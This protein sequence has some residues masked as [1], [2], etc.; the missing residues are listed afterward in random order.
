M[1][2]QRPTLKEIKAQVA[3]DIQSALPGSDPLLRFSNLGIIGVALANMGNAEYGYLDW[4]AKQGVPF[5]ATDEYLYAWG[6][7]KGVIPKPATAAN[8][9]AIT[10]TGANGTII[11]DQTPLVRGDGAAFTV[12]GAVEIIGGLAIVSASANVAGAPGNSATGIVMNLGTAIAGVN[13]TGSV[14]TAFTD[15]T[16]AE[17]TDAYRSRMLQVYAQPPQGGAQSD[18]VEW[19]L[20][21]PGVTRAWCNPNGFG[22][23]TVVVY[24]MLD[25]SE[26]A[27]SGFP[28]GTNGVA[29][30]ETRGV[31]AT[32][33]QLTVADHIYPLRP[34]TALVYSVAPIAQSINFT[35]HGV[36]VGSRAAVTAELSA[37]LTMQGTATGGSIPIMLA[38][39]AVAAVT[40]V[41]DFEIT[42]PTTDIVTTVGNLPVIGTVTYT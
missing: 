16:D 25:I 4:I 17:K 12:Q 9:G 22:P 38:W 18:Y 1:P 6:A 28:Q 42:A 5:T 15:G 13:S 31:T 2:Y 24:T 35:I 37:L 7:L 32:G 40:G 26:S 34:C 30:L 21:V 39:L 41:T 33:D 10:F 36:P 14:T 23:G 19:A 20:A 29:A 3:S 11:P 27:Q 8:N